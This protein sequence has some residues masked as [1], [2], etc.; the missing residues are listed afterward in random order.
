MKTNTLITAILLA[1]LCATLS[2]SN[3]SQLTDTSQF[4]AERVFKAVGNT[5]P[6]YRAPEKKKG[7]VVVTFDL[8]PTRM[9]FTCMNF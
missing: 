1:F 4:R 3:I 5:D 2:F 7:V 9:S 6:D 8:L